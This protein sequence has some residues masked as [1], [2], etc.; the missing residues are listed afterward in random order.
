MGLD[1]RRHTI[2]RLSS[3]VPSGFDTVQGLA[4]AWRKL[5]PSGFAGVSRISEGNYF[6]YDYVTIIATTS[7]LDDDQF[8]DYLEAI[9]VWWEHSLLGFTLSKIFPVAEVVSSFASKFSNAA[10]LFILQPQIQSGECTLLE[11]LAG[12]DVEVQ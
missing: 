3:G 2:E 9:L 6:E 1:R 4:P 11:W 12:K 10:H 8:D 7:H 5:H